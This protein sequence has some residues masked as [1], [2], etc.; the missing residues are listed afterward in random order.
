MPPKLVLWGHTHTYM[1]FYF[2]VFWEDQEDPAKFELHVELNVTF[3]IG[4]T[5]F[6]GQFRVVQTMPKS[7]GEA[8]LLWTKLCRGEDFK[9]KK[10]Y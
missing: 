1:L 3:E 7:R 4:Y 6:L 5:K 9:L 2:N 10:V 8:S